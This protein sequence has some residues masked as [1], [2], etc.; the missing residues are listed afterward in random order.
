MWRPKHTLVMVTFALVSCSTPVAPASTPTHGAVTLRLY[1]T[2]AS[3]PLLNDLTS[4]Y[5][6]THPNV[7]FETT[8]GNFQTMIEQLQQNRDGYLLSNHLP[9]DNNLLAWPIGQDGIAVIAHPQNPITGLTSEELRSIY[10]GHMG[11]WSELGGLDVPLTI[12][13]REDGSS[14]RSEFEKLLLGERMT[15]KSAQIAPSSGAMLTSVAGMTNS[16]GYVSMSYLDSSVQA[17]AIDGVK[18]SPATV[19]DN[20]YPLRSNLYIVGID[21]PMN[22]YRDFIGWI[23]TPEGQ[24]IVGMHYAPL[25][26]PLRS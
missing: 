11:N 3:I 26:T 1:A 19:Y 2:T 20:T 13:S 14:T 12:M 4:H 6:E 21:E 7:S 16:I 17:L 8:T 25:P 24:E 15:T 18:P 22:A 9:D 5:S 10:L 23:Q